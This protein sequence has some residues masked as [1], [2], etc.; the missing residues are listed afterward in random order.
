MLKF[1]CPLSFFRLML[2]TTQP[3]LSITLSLIDKERLNCHSLISICFNNQRSHLCIRTETTFQT[4]INDQFWSRNNHLTACSLSEA[5]GKRCGHW[6][7]VG[8]GAC[9]PLI[10]WH[11]E[12]LRLRVSGVTDQYVKMRSFGAMME[13]WHTSCQLPWFIVTATVPEQESPDIGQ[14]W[15]AMRAPDS[16]FGESKPVNLC[17]PEVINQHEIFVSRVCEGKDEFY[18]CTYYVQI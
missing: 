7:C 2:V 8:A 15:P 3:I 9:S 12:V 17:P 10:S 11:T 4:W 13:P 16:G 6:Y 1:T 18:M 14:L 5:A